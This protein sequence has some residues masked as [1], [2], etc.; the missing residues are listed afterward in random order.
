MYLDSDELFS[1][2]GTIVVM[3]ENETPNSPQYCSVEQVKLWTPYSE[4]DFPDDQVPDIIQAASREVTLKTSKEWEVGDIGYD[5]IE[6]ITAFLAGS[7][8]LGTQKDY[9]GMAAYQKKAYDKLKTLLDSG[10]GPGAE[11]SISDTIN[12]QTPY[13]SYYMAM[14]ADPTQTVVKPYKSVK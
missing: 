10:G 5:D 1:K 7:M 6:I 8:I 13:R 2:K 11:G 4:R 12:V 9:E 14:T 3:S